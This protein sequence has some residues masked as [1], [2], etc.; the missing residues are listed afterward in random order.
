M[1]E[2]APA[3]AKAPVTYSSVGISIDSLDAAKEEMAGHLEPSDPRVLNRLGAF[4]S[5]F[6]A[7]FPAVQ[8]PVLVLK[9]EEPGSKQ[10]LAVQHGCLPGIAHDTIN[11]LVND[12]MMTGA[13][14]LAVLDTIVCGAME[15]EVIVPL[16]AELAAACRANGCTLVGGETSVQ[17]GVLTPGRYVITAAALGV[18]D[19]PKLLDGSAIRPGDELVVVAS[20]GL[21]TNGYT[22]VRR[23]LEQNPALAE[24]PVGDATFLEAVL[25]PHLTYRDGLLRA[26]E[27][28][29]L[30]GAAHITGGGIAGNLVRVLPANVDARFDLGAL[31]IPAVFPVIRQEAGLPD[32]EMLSTFNLGAGLVLVTAPGRSA[33]VIE[34]FVAAG[35]RAYTAGTITEGTGQVRFEGTLRWEKAGK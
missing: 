27:T 31:E 34:A 4:A 3:E 14:P 35:N 25:L 6:A 20:N 19:R 23:L 1:P 18:V 30:T 7:D 8:E 24:Q 22:L 12:V 13:T 29:A 15:R 32:D 16:V 17:P 28:G 2:G 21:H 10:L 9:A 33:E 5:L 26:F 11:H